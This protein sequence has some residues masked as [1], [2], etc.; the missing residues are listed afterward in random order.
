V[1]SL[2]EKKINEMV[3]NDTCK[4]DPSMFSIREEST[5]DPQPNIRW[6]LGNP[7]EVGKEGL[8]ELD[9]GKPT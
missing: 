7:M 9:K 5:R 1:D 4:Q 8:Y 6:V 3:P 2:K